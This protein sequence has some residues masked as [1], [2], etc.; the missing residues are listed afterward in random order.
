MLMIKHGALRLKK[1]KLAFLSS[2]VLFFIICLTVFSGCKTIPQ[3]NKVS[4]LSLL[5]GE[6][7]FYISVP[8]ASYP[9]LVKRV[10]QNNVEGLTEKDSEKVI[11]RIH[12]IYLGISH[13]KDSTVIQ[14]SVE[15]NIPS[16]FMG[17]IFTSK[18][19]FTK[20]RYKPVNSNI[21]VDYFSSLSMDVAQPSVD[22]LCL[23]R[24][25]HEMLDFYSIALDSNQINMD[26]I[27]YDWLI[28]SELNDEIRFYANKPQSFLSILTGTKLNL[29]LFDVYGLMK[30]DQNNQNQY[31]MD[32]DFDF[33]NE[34]YAK[35]GSVMLGFAFGLTDSSY[36]MT[37][38]THL[39]ITGIKIDKKQLYKLL[40]I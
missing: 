16:V 35:V 33:K 20:S 37:S 15:C 22:I 27:V 13:T 21:E 10:L 18:K 4:A 5:D 23:G 39:S 19:G 32:I 36:Q 31:I 30:N 8:G 11:S 6:S 26:Q 34:K 28:E 2:I 9:E 17:R 1:S 24:Q 12:N 7:A 25:V 40:I 29:Q 14:A 38:P 3:V